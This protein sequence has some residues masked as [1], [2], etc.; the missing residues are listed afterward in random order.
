[1]ILLKANNHFLEKYQR[2]RNHLSLHI[3]TSQEKIYI[4][5]FGIVT[6]GEV[7]YFLKDN[8]YFNF[9]LYSEAEHFSENFNV[10]QIQS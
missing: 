8:M 5:T 3:I 6:I 1:L 4:F 10:L 7:S 9:N 2:F